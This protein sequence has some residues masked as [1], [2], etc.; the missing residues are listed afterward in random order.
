VDI[1][2]TRTEKVL[3]I[4]LTAAALVIAGVLVRRELFPPSA[5]R[6]AATNSSPV[7]LKDW[8]EYAGEG[9]LV[10]DSTAKVKVLV[11]SDFQCPFCRQFHSVVNGVSQ[12]FEGKVA[13]VFIHFPLANHPLAR[14][15][16]RAAECAETQG[17]FGLFADALFAKQ[18]SLGLKSW[19][20]YAAEAGV[21]DSAKFAQCVSDSAPI[22]R[23]DRGRALG[24]TLAVSGTPTVLVNGWRFSNPPSDSLLT[25]VVTDLLASKKP[26]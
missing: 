23:I 6:A 18:D 3:N 24:E 1:V 25:R 13:Y 2:T 9:V 15:A 19:A 26:F 21:A 4:L 12:K 5:A 14:P 7:Y 20:S 16:A 8:Q 10:G 17:R 22:S 11:F